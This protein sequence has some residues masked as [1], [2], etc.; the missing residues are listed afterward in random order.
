[1][2]NDLGLR[3]SVT[4]SSFY[5]F[6]FE[7]LSSD[8]LRFFQKGSQLFVMIQINLLSPYLLLLSIQIAMQ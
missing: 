2:L 5:F 8:S 6:L 3:K 4:Q 7:K 1:M